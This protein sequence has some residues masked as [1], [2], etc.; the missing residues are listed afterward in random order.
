MK[1]HSLNFRKEDIPQNISFTSNNTLK[2]NDKNRKDL[3]VKK[4]IPLTKIKKKEK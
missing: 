4:I 3:N 1:I 2:S